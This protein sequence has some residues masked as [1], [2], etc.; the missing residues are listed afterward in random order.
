MVT[1]KLLLAI[2]TIKHWHIF[3]LDINNAFLNGDLNEEV[4]MHLPKGLT[5]SNSSNAGSNLVC[6]LHKSI[7][8]LKQS[9]RQWYKTLTDALLQEG[10][11][12]SQAD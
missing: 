9:S 7:Y 3:Q 12:Q 6:K 10:F 5:I 8:G 11:Q 4:Y 1:F 2:S